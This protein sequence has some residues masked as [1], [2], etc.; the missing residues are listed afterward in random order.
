MLVASP[1]A[2][3][4]LATCVRVGTAADSST[5]SGGVLVPE[6]V[7]LAKAFSYRHN[8]AAAQL[9]QMRQVRD[10][11]CIGGIDVQSHY[12]DFPGRASQR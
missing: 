2:M 12:M 11:P 6:T 5:G 4:A 7:A 8:A 1:M 9:Q 10:Q 3:M